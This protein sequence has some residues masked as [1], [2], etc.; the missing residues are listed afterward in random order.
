MFKHM[1][2]MLINGLLVVLL[3]G[4]LVMPMTS[5]GL[6]GYKTDPQVEVLSAQDQPDDNLW[7]ERYFKLLEK[8]RSEN[9]E[10]TET[11]E[12]LNP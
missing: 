11:T 12:T 10:S 6:M 9:A 4:I 3:L 2:T 7:R 8:M 1:H 5:L